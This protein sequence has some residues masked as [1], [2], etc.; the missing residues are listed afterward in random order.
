MLRCSLRR[1]GFCGMLRQP[2][3]GLLFPCP[4]RLRA[5]WGSSGSARGPSRIAEESSAATVCPWSGLGVLRATRR[6]LRNAASACCRASLSLSWATP[7]EVGIFG[8]REGISADRRGVFS[9]HLCPWGGLGGLRATRMFL[10][11]AASACCR[12]CISLSWATPGEV[13]IFREREGAFADRRGV[14]S[15]HGVPLGRPLGAQSDEEAY[16]ECCVSLL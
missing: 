3:V 4:G 11:N 14:F 16:A 8:E 12:D 6:F 10:R 1:G 5:R 7:G 2:G 9:G 13:G 15:G